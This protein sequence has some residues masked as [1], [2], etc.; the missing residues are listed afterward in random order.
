MKRFIRF[1]HQDA[2]LGEISPNDVMSLVRR[3]EING[4]HSLT[5]TTLQVLGKGERIVY[6]DERGVWRE[7]EVTGVDEEHAAGTRIIGTY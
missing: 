6:Q 3:E 5:I 7:Y 2:P 4:E 1:S